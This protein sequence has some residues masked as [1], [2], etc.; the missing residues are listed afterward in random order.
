MTKIE[1]LQKEFDDAVKN[2]KEAFEGL[3]AEI[4]SVDKPE[5][6]TVKR[7]AKVGERILITNPDDDSAGE[8]GEVF[9]VVDVEP[10]FGHVDVDEIRRNGVWAFMLHEYEV[11]VPEFETVKRNSKI[12]ERVLITNASRFQEGD[13]YESGDVMKVTALVSEGSGIIMCGAYEQID[14]HEYEVITEPETNYLQL[15][16]D[17]AN[18]K[19]TANEQRA[20]LIEKVKEFVEEQTQPMAISRLSTEKGI[21]RSGYFVRPKFIIN[22]EKRTVVVL[23]KRIDSGFVL[24]KGIAKCMPDEVF[25]E[26]I[27]KAIA[28]ARAL[29][30][31]IPVEFLNAVQ[32]DEVVVGMVT[33]PKTPQKL[34]VDRRVPLTVTRITGNQIWRGNEILEEKWSSPSELK[35]INDTNAIYCKEDLK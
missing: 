9:T 13:A 27:G 14:P 1:M 10:A 21:M 18:A 17:E 34:D 3:K 33:E 15:M 11:L 6:K 25:N 30:I 32:P 31:A 12:G 24:F 16:L 8:K 7:P 19:M 35:I 4:I 23:L 2:I 29:E 20:E 28:L 5:Y 22:E 26:H